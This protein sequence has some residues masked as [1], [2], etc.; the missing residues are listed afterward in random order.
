M[1]STGK[2]WIQI[3]N[4]LENSCNITLE[5]ADKLNIIK[6]HFEDLKSRKAEL[7]SILIGLAKPYQEEIDIILIAIYN[8]LKNKEPYNAELYK[9][10]DILPTER[11]ITIEQ[12]LLII[13]NHSYKI[14]SAT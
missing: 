4:V 11:E 5:Q 10:S 6:I 12:A 1:E 14:K 2:Y 9:K 3:F 8:M 13:Q 7:E